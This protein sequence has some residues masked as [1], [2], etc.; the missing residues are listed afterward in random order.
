[1]NN[2]ARKIVKSFR[3]VL[4]CICCLHGL[5]THAQVTTFDPTVLSAIAGANN[6]APIVAPAM[7]SGVIPAGGPDL[8]APPS[9]PAACIAALE[10]EN[11]TVGATEAAVLDAHNEQYGATVARA[12]TA[13]N[14]YGQSAAASQAALLNAAELGNVEQGME[15]DRHERVMAEVR[16]YKGAALMGALATALVTGAAIGPIGGGD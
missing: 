7:P 15:L 11:G 4:S 13:T 10:T 14:T 1:M 3:F 16:R 6:G 2:P 5:D 8:C 9:V 12:S